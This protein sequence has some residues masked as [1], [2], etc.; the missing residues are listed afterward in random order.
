VPTLLIAAGVPASAMAGL[1]VNEF[2]R[3][4]G[5][6]FSTSRNHAIWVH[7]ILARED[8][9]SV[10][11]YLTWDRP[12]SYAGDFT[13]DAYQAFRDRYRELLAGPA[14]PADGARPDPL[15]A[16]DLERAARA[17]EFDTFDPS[18]AMRCLLAALP[19]PEARRMLALV[20]GDVPR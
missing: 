10:R 7:E 11:A 5:E 18:L 9:G 4:D 13:L 6:K 1:V 16:P 20:T 15:T 14:D 17:L 19:A 3:L 2:Y 8:A 12:D